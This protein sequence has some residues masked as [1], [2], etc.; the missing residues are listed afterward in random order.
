MYRIYIFVSAFLLVIF[1]AKVSN[2]I[3]ITDSYFYS[4]PDKFGL[5]A[6]AQAS[7]E[8]FTNTVDGIGTVVITFDAPPEQDAFSAGTGNSNDVGNWPS[9]TPN[10]ITISGN[11]AY[12]SVEILTN[13]WLEIGYGG[14]DYLYFGNLVGD[15]NFDGTLSPLDALLVIDYLND[16]SGNTGTG[17]DIDGDG[18]VSPIDAL[19]IVNLLNENVGDYPKLANGPFNPFSDDDPSI[20]FFPIDTTP[21]QIYTPSG[22]VNIFDGETSY[23]QSLNLAL[24]YQPTEVDLYAIAM[25]TPVPEP[26][27]MLLLGSGLMALAG[28]GRRFRKTGRSGTGVREERYGKSPAICLSKEGLFHFML[29]RQKMLSK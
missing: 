25:V 28:F 22:T 2:A 4:N 26:A 3:S 16:S 19:I 1:F 24:I 27:T 7:S 17:Y 20:G 29:F 14:S 6:N 10:V 12:I 8:N 11:Q 5:T 23:D 13:G 9:L 15:A 18:D 21:F